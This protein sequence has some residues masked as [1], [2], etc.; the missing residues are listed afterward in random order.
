MWEIQ[1]FKGL[2]SQAAWPSYDESKTIESERE[3]AVQ[4]GGKLKT[5]V[6]VVN[7]ADDDTVLSAV[8]ADEKMKKLLEGK[9]I[10]RV[11]VVKNKLIN[12]II[13]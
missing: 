8:K 1:G 10:I 2:A 11:I 7:D 5:T 9:E 13:K 12:L 3:I 4:V 6:M